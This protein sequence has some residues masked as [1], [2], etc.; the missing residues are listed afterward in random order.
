MS[1]VTKLVLRIVI[2][3]IRAIILQEITSEQ[4]GFMPDKGTGNAIFVLRM[5]VKRSI[6]KQK[7]V[8]VCFID[9][10]KAFDTT[11]SCWWTYYNH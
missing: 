3:R 5:I 2:N 8:Y 6:K 1:D 4:Y 11:Q 10:S 9:Y 7:D